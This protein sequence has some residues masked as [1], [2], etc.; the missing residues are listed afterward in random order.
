MIVVAELSVARILLSTK[1]YILEMNRFQ[2]A[3]SNF[4]YKFTYH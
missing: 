2:S 4:S 3:L 1:C